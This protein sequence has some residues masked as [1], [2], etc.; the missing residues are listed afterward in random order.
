MTKPVLHVINP[1]KTA[2]VVLDEAPWIG[3]AIEHT[4]GTEMLHPGDRVMITNDD[5]KW[6]EL[7]ASVINN[8]DRVIV[9]GSLGVNFDD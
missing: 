3:I 6:S 5:F 1:P 7:P 2:V 8:E 4:G 9:L